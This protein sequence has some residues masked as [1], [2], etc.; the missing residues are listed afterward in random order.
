M[1]NQKSHSHVLRNINRERRDGRKVHA[2]EDERD[3]PAS[4]ERT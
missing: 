4:D 1:Y 3:D 2:K